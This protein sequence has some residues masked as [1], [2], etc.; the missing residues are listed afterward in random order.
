MSERILPRLLCSPCDFCR[1]RKPDATASGPSNDESR[2]GVRVDLLFD[3][4]IV[5]CCICSSVCGERSGGGGG[6]AF[7]VGPVFLSF[8]LTS[9]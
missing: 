2:G 4:L 8:Y 1:W 9:L 5:C 6:G 3:C 7:A